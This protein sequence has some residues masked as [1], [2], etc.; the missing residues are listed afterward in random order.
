MLKRKKTLVSSAPCLKHFAECAAAT[1]VTL[2][3]PMCN[4]VSVNIIWNSNMNPVGQW[5]RWR[6]GTE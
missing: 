1:L 5:W 4:L 2:H 3:R 6:C